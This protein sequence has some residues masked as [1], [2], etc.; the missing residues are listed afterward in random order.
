[1]GRL[2]AQH[3][4]KK[5]FGFGMPPR[6]CIQRGDVGL[7][8]QVLRAQAERDIIDLERFRQPARAAQC[9]GIDQLCLETFRRGSC[10]P[11]VACDVLLLRAQ[12]VGS[13]KHRGG[14][15]RPPQ[16]L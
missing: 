5:R 9:I 6:L 7:Q 10:F 1:M 4:I 13:G 11:P 3:L 14:L 16:I 8:R 12:S 15:I 2:D